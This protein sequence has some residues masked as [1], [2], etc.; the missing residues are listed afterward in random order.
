MKELSGKLEKV[1]FAI[2]RIYFHNFIGVLAWYWVGRILRRKVAEKNELKLF[3]RLVP[4]LSA[5][6]RIVR[7]P[8]GLN[9]V[10]RA[11]KP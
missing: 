4:I 10:C 3:D 8:F 9:L 1:G 5:W 11:V 7:P 6:E 2:D